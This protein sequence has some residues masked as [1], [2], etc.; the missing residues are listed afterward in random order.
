MALTDTKLKMLKPDDKPYKVP[1]RDG[2]YVVVSVKGTISFRYDY[3]VSD[4]RRAAANIYCPGA[5][6]LTNR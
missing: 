2:M 5:T 6:K 3:R 4:R 1:D